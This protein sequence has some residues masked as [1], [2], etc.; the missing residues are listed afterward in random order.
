[1]YGLENLIV[2]CDLVIKNILLIDIGIVKIVDMGVV[3]VF[4]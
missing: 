4:V 3:K 1:M 2:Y